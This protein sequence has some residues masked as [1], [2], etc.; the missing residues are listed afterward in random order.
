MAG[1]D[2]PDAAGPPIKLP[3]GSAVQRLPGFH[4]WLWDGEFCGVIGFRWQPGSSTLAPHVLGHI[5][6]S[7]VAWKRGQGYAKA[8]LAL[9]LPAARARGLTYVEL[10][11]DLGNIASQRVIL[12]NRG[13]LVERFRKAAVYG[14]AEA[15]RF[16]IDL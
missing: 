7:V 3:D 6:F 9:L 10:T 15:F 11:A 2:D 13:R 16:R 8:A 12:C 14:G 5:G 1:Q 4:R